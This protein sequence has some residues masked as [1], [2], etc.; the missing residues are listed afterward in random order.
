M[1]T[2]I[3][4]RTVSAEEF[5]AWETAN[6]LSFGGHSTD[7]SIEI[8]RSFAELDRTFA[9]FARTR[10][11][12]RIVGTATIRTSAVTV[13]GG[14]LPLGFVD[15]VTVLPT[16]RRR[17]IL[18]RMMRR[19][20]EQMRERGEPLAALTASESLIYERFGFG[21]A[22]SAEEWRIERRHTSMKFPSSGDDALEL[23][24]ADTA[25][26][27]WPRLYARVAPNRVG[28]V[29]YNDSY[30]RSA[31]WDADSQRRGATPFFHVICVRDGRVAGMCAYRIRHSTVLVIF[32]LG[33]D[34]EVEAAMW[35]YCFGIDLRDTIR[36][37]N[38]P[39]DDPLP[40]RLE[41]PRRLERAPRD[42]MWLR[43]VDLAAALEHRAY[44]K[45]G[46]LTLKVRDD[47]C[48]WNDG[49]YELNGDASGGV[50]ART[51]DAPMIELTAADLAAAYLGGV[52]FSTLARAGRVEENL[53]GALRLADDM[54]RTN[55]APWS[56]EL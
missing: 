45:S 16:H 21:I 37:F 51:S 50:C 54:F 36:A 7:E 42:H 24:S 10:H 55:R 12:Q 32:L 18:R 40:W 39:V 30:W 29:H 20:L 25:R 28:M 13:P 52:S 4:I 23:V 34:A 31:L 43:L 49:T 5:P 17:G 46:S 44:S 2:D 8:A 35:R 14:T 19:Q 27:E 26:D 9:A 47:F 33:E 56:L 41:D 22:T 3:D 53:S 6:S 48:E 15:D 11:G 38:Q 1:D